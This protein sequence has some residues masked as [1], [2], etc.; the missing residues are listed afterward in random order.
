[1]V[2][3]LTRVTVYLSHVCEIKN[4]LARTLQNKMQVNV[5]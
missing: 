3:I 2:E 1:M 4:E 5:N